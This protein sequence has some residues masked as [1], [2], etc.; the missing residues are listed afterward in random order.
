M[1]YIYI[2][3]IFNINYNFLLKEEYDYYEYE[4]TFDEFKENLLT[5]NYTTKTNDI[6][7]T[8]GFTTVLNTTEYKSNELSKS[9]ST[10]TFIIIASIVMLLAI[11]LPFIFIFKYMKKTNNENE[12]VLNELHFTTSML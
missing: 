8:I 6:E 4:N 10:L 2:W 11:I 7:H 12:V 5:G 9:D 1:I 3:L